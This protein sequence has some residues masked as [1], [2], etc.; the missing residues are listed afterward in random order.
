MHK[1]NIMSFG[2]DENS[3]YSIRSCGLAWKTNVSCSTFYFLQKSF[4][5]VAFPKSAKAGS[6]NIS[7]KC[8]YSE[9]GIIIFFCKFSERQSLKKKLTTVETLGRKNST[10][11]NAIQFN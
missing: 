7:V 2:N 6:E 10:R 3:I 9:F 1:N 8:R 4:T 11:Q 5:K